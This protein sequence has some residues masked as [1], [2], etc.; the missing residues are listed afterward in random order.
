MC[1]VGSASGPFE[2]PGGG[3]MTR[4]RSI[5]AGFRPERRTWLLRGQGSAPGVPPCPRCTTPTR[6]VPMI[7]L[8]LLSDPEVVHKILSHLGIPTCVPALA[9][10]RSSAPPTGARRALAAMAAGAESR[11]TGA[12]TAPETRA[13]AW[14]GTA[15]EAVFS[16]RRIRC[17]CLVPTRVLLTQWQ[18]EIGRVYLGQVGI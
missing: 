14:A 1:L 3:V 8:A 7:V 18:A 16:P 4:N 11:E 6:T 9:P 17:L 15:A 5:G 2:A 13:H 12:E 10:A